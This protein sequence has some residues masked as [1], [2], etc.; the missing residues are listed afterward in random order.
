M[1][2]V[3]LGRMSYPATVQ[4]PKSCLAKHPSFTSIISTNLTPHVSKSF[5]SESGIIEDKRMTYLETDQ[6]YTPNSRLQGKT[7]TKFTSL[8][9]QM[10]ALLIIEKNQHR[11]KHHMLML[12][13][14]LCTL[15][16]KTGLDCLN[17][18][19]CLNQVLLWETCLVK[20][21]V[22]K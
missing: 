7:T 10:Q 14:D 1:K 9:Q 21:S 4:P 6:S 20:M 18:M 19:T 2:V 15:I 17:T 12:R 8:L 22:Q 16:P 11:Q 3:L 13:K 5:E